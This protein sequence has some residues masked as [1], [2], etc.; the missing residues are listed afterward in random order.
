[1]AKYN[2]LTITYYYSRI[3]IVWLGNPR[4]S[5]IISCQFRGVPGEPVLTDQ[6]EVIQQVAWF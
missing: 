4:I 6:M 3:L 2:L 1:M 5:S